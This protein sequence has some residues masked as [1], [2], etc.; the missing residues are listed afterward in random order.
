M[1]I[2]LVPQ[3]CGAGELHIFKV[4][5]AGSQG[6]QPRQQIVVGSPAGQPTRPGDWFC[7]GDSRPLCLQI[8]CNIFV[9][10]VEAG[11]PKPMG[12]RAQ[13]YSRFE[14]VNRSAMTKAV[15]V[16]AL[17]VQRWQGHGCP[18]HVSLEDEAR[19]ESCKL[20]AAM[21]PEQGLGALRIKPGVCKVLL[22]QAGRLRPKRTDALSAAFA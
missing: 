15:R 1:K 2:H 10:R 7:F 17:A 6:F 5:Y 4:Q 22:Q 3:C 11:V 16:D 19:S 18:L 12:N 20:G 13:I 8:H 14:Q 21:V 9:R